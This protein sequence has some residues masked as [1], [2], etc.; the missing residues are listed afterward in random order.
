VVA[1]AVASLLLLLEELLRLLSLSLPF[2]VAEVVDESRGVAVEDLDSNPSRSL[3]S[4]SD[5][6]SFVI[7]AYLLLVGA[8]GALR[9]LPLP[10]FDE[11]SCK[12]DELGEMIDDVVGIAVA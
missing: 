2:L 12:D 1:A 6:S 3:S 11:E 8:F 5:I 10:R 4:S 7:L 9:G